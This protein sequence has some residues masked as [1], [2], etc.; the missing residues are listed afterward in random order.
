MLNTITK[1]FSAAP[2]CYS[3]I[4]VITVVSIWAIK[5]QRVFLQL[6]LYPYSIFN[7]RE[8]YRLFTGDL[9]HNDPVHLFI[10]LMLLFTF[11]TRLEEYLI[12]QTVIGSLN[13]LLVYGS[14]CLAGSLVTSIRHRKEEDFMNVGASGSIIG[15]MLGYVLLQP[16]IIAFYVPVLGGIKNIFGGLICIVAFMIFQF[17]SNRGNINHEVH[18]FGGLGGIAATYFIHYCGSS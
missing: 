8:H 6:L 3:L 13:F 5:V 17:R 12:T 4:A 14:S 15:C 9:V 7:S 18:F 2:V 10:N 16:N 11:G 1:A